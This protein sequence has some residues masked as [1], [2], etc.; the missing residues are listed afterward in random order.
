[1]NASY[2]IPA[3]SNLRQ[4]A[5]QMARQLVEERPVF[6]DTET[7]GLD[8]SA[9]IVEISIVDLDGSI[10][11]ESYVR[12]SASIPAAATRIHHITNKMVEKAPTW[13][14]VWPIVRMHLVTRRIAIY[15]EEYD[16]RLMQQSHGRYRLP[17]KENL[18]T[19]CIMKLY[20]QF[21]GDWDPLRRSYRFH[22]L[23]NAG[24]QCGLNLPNSHR[25]TDDTLLTRSVLLFMAGQRL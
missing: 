18:K 17:W 19:A 1:V 21:K 8:R 25:A 22:N 15:N 14:A 9:E 13:P 11:F 7:T 4:K 12:P 2:A 16:L 3:G 24:K 23:A 6:L 10:L 20:A 5:I